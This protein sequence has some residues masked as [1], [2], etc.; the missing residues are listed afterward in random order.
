MKWVTNIANNKFHYLLPLRPLHLTQVLKMSLSNLSIANNARNKP[1]IELI[2]WPGP[3]SSAADRVF[4]QIGV[5]KRSLNKV[6]H[7]KRSLSDEGTRC[8]LLYD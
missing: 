6:F 7:K 8:L 4:H 3:V 2:L 5:D 1:I